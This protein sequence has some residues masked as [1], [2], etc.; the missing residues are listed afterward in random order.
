MEEFKIVLK[1]RIVLLTIFNVLAV[2]FVGVAG[3]WGYNQ[4]DS[5]GHIYDFMHGLQVGLFAAFVFIVLKQILMYNKAFK[6]D[7]KLRLVYIEE[8]DERKKL[9]SDKIGGVGYN[10]VL[11]SLIIAVVVAGFFSDVVFITLFC[12]LLFMSLVKGFLKIYYNKKY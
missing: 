11:G 12:A 7:E 8:N 1:R 6:D 4:I 3:V 5:N 10:F 9:I 2:I